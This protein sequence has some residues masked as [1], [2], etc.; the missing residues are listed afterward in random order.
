[1]GVA[2]QHPRGWFGGAR[3]RHFGAAPLVEDNSVRSDSTTVVNLEMGRR[4]GKRLSVA[5]AAF[6]VL[7]SDDNDITYFYESRLAGEAAPAAD[8]HFH[9]VEPR[10]LRLTVETRF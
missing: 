8:R 7:G 1:M 4:F 6:N 9:P 10:T 3:F 5:L 2:L